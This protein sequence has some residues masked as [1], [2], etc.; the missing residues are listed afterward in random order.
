M[1]MLQPESNSQP[2]TQLYLLNEAIACQIL[3]NCAQ[4]ALIT[5]EEMFQEEKCWKQRIVINMLTMAY[6]LW[7]VSCFL[8][9]ANILPMANVVVPCTYLPT[10]GPQSLEDSLRGGRVT[11]KA[12]VCFYIF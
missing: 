8:Y 12:G 9:G 3:Y 2:Q 4:T 11:K 5:A 7:H 6:L 10:W 1:R